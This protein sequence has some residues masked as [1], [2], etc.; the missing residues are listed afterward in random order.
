MKTEK[1]VTDFQNQNG[2]DSKAIPL[3]L[4]AVAAILWSTGGLLI[5]YVAW[6]PLAVSGMRSGIACLVL[7]AFWQVKTRTL[8]PGL[9]KF[10]FLAGINYACLVTFFVVANKL[11][12]SANAILLQFTAP[13]WILLFSVWF[14]KETFAKKDYAVVMVVF[15]GMALFFIGD[16]NGGNMLG[17]FFGVLSGINMALM[18]ISL[19][20]IK[21]GS[22]L[23]IV[24]W[25]NFFAFL[26]AT[27]FYGSMIMTKES[28]IGISFLGIFQV[29][30]AYIFFTTGIQRVST[31]EGILIPV[32]EPLL[33]PVWVL[34]GTGE[35]PTLSAIVGGVIVI[36]AVVYKSVS[37]YYDS[38]KKIIPITGAERA[39][40]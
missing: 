23:E 7:I 40:V 6:H 38:K 3:L 13:A 37:D 1:T 34:I 29:G 8:L 26:I 22:P 15:L 35:I 39:T 36:S 14:F 30:I 5:K 24:I 17:N 27:P 20:R 4:V 11:T 33:N 32:L 31:L 21:N 18:I 16:I 12:T 10:R 25:G 2:I 28:L 19:K 9:D